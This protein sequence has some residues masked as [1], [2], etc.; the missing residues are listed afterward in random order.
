MKNPVST[1]HLHVKGRQLSIFKCYQN[2]KWTCHTPERTTN[3]S[4]FKNC[5][6]ISNTSNTEITT[7]ISILNNFLKNTE[8]IILPT[9]YNQ[10]INRQDLYTQIM[11][12]IA[13]L[14]P[15]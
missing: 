9:I 2:N 5:Q 4:F 8:F 15:A 14:I 13:H 1:G 12:G 7:S 10:G 11:A 3:L 6:P